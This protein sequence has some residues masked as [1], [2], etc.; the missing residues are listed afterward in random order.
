MSARNEL[1]QRLKILKG[2]EKKARRLLLKDESFTQAIDLLKEI[3]SGYREIGAIEKA[4]ILE[5]QLAVILKEH[6]I[7]IDD[8]RVETHYKED[9]SENILN[10]IESLERKVK[11]RL[12]Q[13]RIPEAIED[14]K[15]II[16]ELRRIKLFEKADLLETTLNQ[17]IM[18]ISGDSGVE[19]PVGQVSSPVQA[20]IPPAKDS[21]RPESQIPSNNQKLRPPFIPFSPAPQPSSNSLNQFKPVNVPSSVPAK[22]RFPSESPPI[23]P[24]SAQSQS[25]SIHTIKDEP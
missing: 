14:L 4:R 11:R 18:E 3:I 17:F 20:S 13:G 19:I 16:A 21:I 22:G 7:K 6:D 5:G 24:E 12:L 10:F 25:K 15:Y 9:I 8:I 2:L 23:R 1:E